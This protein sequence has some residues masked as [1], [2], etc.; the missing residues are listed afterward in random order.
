[1]LER[2]GFHQSWVDMVMSCITTVSYSIRTDFFQTSCSLRQG[3]PLSPFLSSY[4]L[5]ASMQKVIQIRGILECCTQAFGKQ[6]NFHKSSLYFTSHTS[7]AFRIETCQTLEV[8]KVNDPVL[9]LGLPLIIGRNTRQV[10]SFLSDKLHSRVQGWS[11]NL[12]SYGG[13]EVYI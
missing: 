9:Y 3:D 4:V 6:I 12:I 5:K 2:L 1:M 7:A 8:E 10:F 13:K 11:E